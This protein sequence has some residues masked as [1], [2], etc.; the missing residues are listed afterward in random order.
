MEKPKDKDF[1]ETI[2][3]LLFCVVGYL[4]PP[5]RY[6]A[7]LKYVPSEGGK[8]KRGETRYAR[9]LPYYH[10]SQV[11]NTYGF[12]RGLFITP[13]GVIPCGIVKAG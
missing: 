8:W 1:I 7:Y 5:D 4:H 12:L 2:E 3:G 6:T 13:G 10:V 9:V 11:E